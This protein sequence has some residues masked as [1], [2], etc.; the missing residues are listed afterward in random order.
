MGKPEPQMNFSTN[1]SKFKTAFGVD[2][3]QILPPNK[4]RHPF[5]ES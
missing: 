4:K 3:S 1:K 5:D 2:G